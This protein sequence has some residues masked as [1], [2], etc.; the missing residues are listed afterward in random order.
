[1]ESAI[2]LLLFRPASEAYFILQEVLD[3]ACAALFPWI[4][5]VVHP[6]P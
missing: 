4:P 5:L 3:P 2:V 1:M 6:I